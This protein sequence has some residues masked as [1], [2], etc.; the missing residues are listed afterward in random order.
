MIRADG[1]YAESLSANGLSNDAQ[2]SG[3]LRKLRIADT[4]D[5]TT[6]LGHGTRWSSSAEEFQGRSDDPDHVEGNVGTLKIYQ[7]GT[8]KWKAQG[9]DFGA[10]YT[11]D[12]GL[13][14]LESETPGLGF[15]FCITDAEIAASAVGGTDYPITIIKGSPIGFIGFDTGTMFVWAQYLNGFQQDITGILGYAGKTTFDVAS[16]INCV[17]DVD[18]HG[19]PIS[20]P[21]NVVHV[22]CGIN[23][24]SALAA[25]TAT[26]TIQ[27][28]LDNLTA[29]K[30]AINAHGACVIFSTLSHENPSVAL[31]G[32]MDQVNDHIDDLQTASPSCV[33]V[34]DYKSVIDNPASPVKAA[35]PDMMSG[36]HYSPR[37][38]A[39]TAGVVLV[40]LLQSIVPAAPA[41]RSAFTGARPS[42]L[43]NS[44]FI[45]TSGTLSAGTGSTCTGV[46]AWDV[47]AANGFGVDIGD[48]GVVCSKEA[49]AGEYHPWQVLTVTGGSAESVVLMASPL[50]PVSEYM[51]AE[52]EYYISDGQNFGSSSYIPQ[53]VFSFYDGASAF[54]DDLSG[55]RFQ[56]G[57]TVAGADG[58]VQSVLKTDVITVPAG[59]V[60]CV[61]FISFGIA[62]STNV[63]AKFRNAGAKAIN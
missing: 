43:A 16:S 28:V 48:C 2:V 8:A 36:P 27:D 20:A 51:Q 56:F 63:V 12:S 46:S 24:C 22:S 15:A 11:L 14:W 60:S 41:G 47:Y 44:D 54:I 30:T 17:F 6:A 26:Y 35:L 55:C 5:S 42:I 4:G 57:G 7:N 10:L 1:L 32:Y 59:A 18:S 31:R 61:V 34:A 40:D 19:K 9:D 62:A 25:G 58:S 45:G 23:D 33:Y 21:P 37:D 53:L 29:I 49:S 38:G 50:T 3:G 39:R 52:M 13:V